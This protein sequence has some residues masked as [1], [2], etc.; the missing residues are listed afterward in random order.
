[1]FLGA[2]FSQKNNY[3]QKGEKMA[4]KDGTFATKYKVGIVIVIASMFLFVVVLLGSIYSYVNGLY[5][6]SV[7]YETQLNVQ[8]LSNQNYLSAYISGF[9]EKLELVKFQS[10]KLNQVLLDAVKGR[11]D[12][13]GFKVG[14]SFFTVIREAYPEQSLAGLMKS[15]DKV[16]NYISAGR[17]GYRAVQDKLL[18]QLRAYDKW[19]ESGIV[20]RLIV[21]DV[22]GVP[23]ERLEARIGANVYK[24]KVARDKMYTLV[25]ASDARKAYETGTMEPLKVQ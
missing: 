24:G 19:R 9:Y 12:K 22:L 18:D 3:H 20:Q 23:S 4:V 10:E 21:G 1:M 25:L 15:F 16:N 17:E 14:S 13:G 11:Y 8:Y 6:A 5:S 7:S 2:D